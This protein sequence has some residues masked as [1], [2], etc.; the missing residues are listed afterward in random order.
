[1]LKRI[2]RRIGLILL[3]LLLVLF[4]AGFIAARWYL[5]PFVKQAAESGVEKSSNGLYR[6]SIKTLRIDLLTGTIRARGL[7]I[8][9]DTA[10]WETRIRQFPAKATQK[11]NL[12]IESMRITRVHWWRFL[13]TGDL[14]L[15]RIEIDKPQLDIASVQDSMPE[16]AP[17]TDS[18]TRSMLDQ[19]P[20]LIAPHAK[21]IR[22][23]LITVENARFVLN[24]KSPEKET[25]QYA[26]SINWKIADIHLAAADTSAAGRTFYANNMLLNLHHYR[27]WTVGK[28]Y[29]FSIE[30]AQLT[31]K[32]SLFE[33]QHCSMRSVGD[34][35]IT[36]AEPR[37]RRPKVYFNIRETTVQGLDLLLGLH[38]NK[39]NARSILLD[40][41]Y[42]SLFNN[43]DLPLPLHRK[44][45]NELW[46]NLKLPVNV[47]TLLVRNAN[48]FYHDKTGDDRGKLNFRNANVLVL[49]LSND[50]TRMTDTTP[51][52]VFA[53]AQF[54]GTGDLSVALSIPLLSP[55]F[56][57]PYQATLLN[58]PFSSINALIE[59][60]NNVR[61]DEGFA[62]KISVKALA[63]NGI[64]RGSVKIYYQG[65][66][67]SVLKEESGDKNKLASTIANLVIRNN[68]DDK[69]TDSPFRTAD[70]V[71]R[72]EAVD[73]FLR[74]LWRA[75]QSGLVNT[76]TNIKVTPPKNDGRD[77]KE[78]QKKAEKREKKAEKL[79]QK[80]E[81]QR[82]AEQKKQ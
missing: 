50:S 6:L 60:K 75:A 14:A 52:R 9:T 68:S 57:C 17:K 79:E 44:M 42:V 41:V 72:R 58:M 33:M 1:M 49:N 28:R 78:Q 48:I 80:K 34:D 25:I 32:D 35:S 81:D 67:I 77:K 62:D 23:K 82:E 36:I 21:S 70:I 12:S 10:R 74:L 71:Y 37:L 29:L 61:I 27:L 31:G 51:V 54:M 2:Y 53:A 26:D 64:T 16:Q 24:T 76:L 43:M 4:L 8:T 11:I 5:A 38:R 13:K 22:I 55:N 3:S 15:N 63:T 45:P 46:R 73:G 69:S 47:D 7:T 40:S 65:L 30:A 56:Y 20:A 18:I 39:W 66:K 19:L 59:A